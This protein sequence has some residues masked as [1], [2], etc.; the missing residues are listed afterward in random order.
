MVCRGW[1]ARG[2]GVVVTPR[3]MTFGMQQQQPQQSTW[4]G[5]RSGGGFVGSATSSLQGR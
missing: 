1:G 5:A 2:G 4:T 3:S